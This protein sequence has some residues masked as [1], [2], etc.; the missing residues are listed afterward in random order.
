MST[1]PDLAIVT[2]NAETL[3]PYP[4]ML[5]IDRGLQADIVEIVARAGARA[6]AMDFYFV[7]ATVKEADEKFVNALIAAKEQLILGAY[8]N[9]NALKPHQLAYQRQFLD[10]VRAPAGY[11]D[12][13]PDADDIVRSRA[14]PAPEASNRDS[15]SARLAEAAGQKH[16]ATPERIA[17]L[18]PPR[19]GS[20]TFLRI[21]AHKLLDGTSGEAARLKGRIV[22]VA[23]DFPFFDRHRT[24]L[25]LLTGADMSGAEI[26][27]HMAAELID[28]DRS[29][30][31]LA[32]SSARILFASLGVLGIALGW[33]FRR[34]RIDFL[35]WRTASIALIVL[36]ALLFK[37]ARIVLPFT[38]AAFAWVLGVTC[39]T[40]LRGAIL[41]L[42]QR[43]GAPTSP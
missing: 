42:H 15:F 4:F 39:G 27:A 5:P 8:E 23:G 26:H 31:E 11:L 41:W 2:I 33:R 16:R 17:W 13:K 22:I 34:R 19:D 40:Q 12:L 20:S 9:P 29:Y 14:T 6:I 7:K 30:S 3:E 35:D 38:L 32:A 21:E 36:D 43:R 37:F 18:L 1:H 10:H 28:G 25:T 24:P